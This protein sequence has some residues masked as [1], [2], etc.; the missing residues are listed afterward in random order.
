MDKNFFSRVV[1]THTIIENLLRPNQLKEIIEES[2]FSENED[3]A[4]YVNGVMVGVCAAASQNYQTRHYYR[5]GYI[6]THFSLRANRG[7]FSFKFD[8][9][10]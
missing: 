5:H 2:D 9:F 6:S 8:I 3:S 1:T 10:I 4:V 7:F